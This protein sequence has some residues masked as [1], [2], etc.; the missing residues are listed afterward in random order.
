MDHTF[1]LTE[2]RSAA[3]RR[4]GVRIL[5]VGGS[6]VLF[7]TLLLVESAVRIRQYFRYG[8]AGAILYKSVVDP[9]LK[10]PIQ[11]PNQTTPTIRINS[12]G[13][14][15]PELSVPK[16]AGT[17]RLAFLGASTTFCAEVSTNELAWP[18]LVWRGLQEHWPDIHFDYVNGSFPGYVVASSLRNLK[19]R[20][21]PLAPDIIVIYDAINDLS[22]DTRELAKDQGIQ[23]GAVDESGLLGRWSLTWFLVEKNL[24][25]MARQRRATD[26]TARNVVLPPAF[27]QAFRQRFR[28][29]VDE[30]SKAAPVVAIATFS[31]KVRREQ[32]A[33]QRL[34]NANTHLY[35]MPY[36]KVEQIL[37]GIDEYNRVIREVAREAGTTLIEGEES[38]PADDR[39]F[40]DSV[41]FTD[42]G[43]RAMA[44]RV[45]TSLISSDVLER[46]VESRRIV[47]KAP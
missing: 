15:G 35:Y 30:S 9:Q 19:H 45:V 11:A 26:E 23:R 14:R 28:E 1:T 24:R 29:L 6:L 10:L 32:S 22:R 25:L 2:V 16:P 36:L 27:S 12:L 37:D 39:H 43:S 4:V 13:F 21:Q 20:I 18:H 34:R 33:E 17:I 5:T 40:T 47:P 38:I 44:R 42:A 46:F 41:H 3:R 7:L 8:S 31:Q